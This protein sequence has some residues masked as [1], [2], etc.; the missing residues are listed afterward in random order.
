MKRNPNPNPRIDH[1]TRLQELDGSKTIEEL[2]KFDKIITSHARF[3]TYNHRDHKDLVQEVYIKLWQWKQKP[4]N[5]N[6]VFTAALIHTCLK[7]AWINVCKKKKLDIDYSYIILDDFLDESPYEFDN[8]NELEEKYLIMEDRISRLH[9]YEQSV[10][11]YSL[12]IDIKSLSRLT[13]ISYR[14]LRETLSKVKQ[15]LKT[16]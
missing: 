3:I 2:I 7:N 6:K 8:K 1:R 16:V 14:S 10:L 13:T 5:I 12:E 11:Q 4:K 15:K 9:W